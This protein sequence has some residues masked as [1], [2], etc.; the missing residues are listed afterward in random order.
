M[1]WWHLRHGRAGFLL[2]AVRLDLV[3]ELV[4]LSLTVETLCYLIQCDS[5]GGKS[6]ISWSYPWPGED[7]VSVTSPKPCQV[8]PPSPSIGWYSKLLMPRSTLCTLWRYPMRSASIWSVSHRELSLHITPSSNNWQAS[9]AF[10]QVFLTFH[11]Q[12]AVTQE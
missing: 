8:I 1:R 4:D 11:H 12:F 5:W 10:R 7:C 6:H 3:M 2:A 9:F